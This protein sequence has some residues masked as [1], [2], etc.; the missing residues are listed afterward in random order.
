MQAEF[1]LSINAYLA[2]LV[3]SPAHSL[4]DIIVFNNQH[5]VQER[6]KDFGQD[7]LIAAQNTKVDRDGVCNR[8]GYQSE[9]ATHV[10]AL[11]GTHNQDLCMTLV[12][13]SVVQKLLSVCSLCFV[14]PYCSII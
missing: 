5:P 13:A 6:M 9:E 10:Q 3:C 11:A 2:D 12:F 14:F 4:A 8:A 7:G 1:K